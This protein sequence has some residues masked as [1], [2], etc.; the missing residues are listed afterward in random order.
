MAELKVF[1]GMKHCMAVLGP[2]ADIYGELRDLFEKCGWEEAII[3]NAIGSF[4]RGVVRYPKT[5]E[6]PPEIATVEYEGPFE[7]ASMVGTIRKE[8]KGI[9]LHLHASFA[10]KGDH[11]FGG[12]LGEGS[13]VYKMLEVFLLVKGGE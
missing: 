12:A 4:A 3:V 6:L 13:T 2:G 1:D 5:R 11:F 10:D 9:N 8:A 7:I